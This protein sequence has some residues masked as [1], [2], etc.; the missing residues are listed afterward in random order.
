MEQLSLPPGR[1]H[2]TPQPPQFASVFRGASQPFDA[3]PS[4]LP[5]PAAHA[6]RV[7][8]PVEQLSAAFGRSQ[9][10]PQ[11]PQWVSVVSGASQPLAS[12]PSQLPTPALQA[13]IAQLPEP[14]V[15]V[16]PARVQAVPHEPQSVVVRSE[17]SQP[18]AIVPSQSS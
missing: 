15:A 1:S 4:Q 14:Q 11:P 9:G 8:L 10:V 2:T 18:F 3:T 5:Y 12:M 17:R 6:P 13:L 16:A 7:Q